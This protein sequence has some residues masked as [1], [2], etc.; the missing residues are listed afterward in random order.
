MQVLTKSLF[1]P[2]SLLEVGGTCADP[3]AGQPQP[4]GHVAHLHLLVSRP[5]VGP[6]PAPCQFNQ[7][8]PA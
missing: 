1:G 6:G 7:L 4:A 3:Q 5:G 8:P 2:V